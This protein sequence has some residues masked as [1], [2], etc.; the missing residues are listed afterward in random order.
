MLAPDATTLV[1]RERLMNATSSD[2]SRP[3]TTA[4]AEAGRGRRF[5]G[6]AAVLVPV[7]LIRCYQA[8]IRPHLIGCCKFQPTCSEYGIE[9]FQVHGP[10]RGAVLTIRRLLRCHPFGPGGVDPV[11]PPPPPP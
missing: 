4:L 7:F 5:A 8:V 10:L 11:P 3:V 6:R 2:E 9:A 1:D